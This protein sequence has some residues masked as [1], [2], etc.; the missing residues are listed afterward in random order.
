M[1]NV[2]LLVMEGIWFQVD[3][4]SFRL[5]QLSHEH[6]LTDCSAADTSWHVYWVGWKDELRKFSCKKFKVIGGKNLTREI[7]FLLL[8]DPC[9]HF[10]ELLKHN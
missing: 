3:R 5:L 6:T 2:N 9:M 10:S 8:S 1:P 7:T 4:S